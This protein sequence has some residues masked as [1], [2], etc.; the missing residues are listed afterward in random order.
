M[1]P[2]HDRLTLPL[3]ARRIF[4]SA[5][6]REFGT[7]RDAL[8]NALRSRGV[9]VEVQSAFRQGEGTTLSK[10]HDYIRGCERVLALVGD[11]SGA[12][13]PPDAVTPDL[14]AML[15]AGWD[16]ASYTQW[17]VIIARHY[18]VATFFFESAGFR[19]EQPPNS[20]DQPEAQARWRNFLFDGGWGM[21]RRQFHSADRIEADVMSLD[22]PRSGKPCNLPGS[23]GH[24]FKG[25]DAFLEDLARS[26]R[27][28]T[29][30]AI[31]GTA[32]HGL[33]GVG[34]T[35]AAI[36]YGYAR[37]DDYSALFFLVG[38]SPNDLTDGLAELCGV[39]ELEQKDAPDLNIRVAAVVRWMKANPGWLLVIDNVDDEAAAGAVQQFLREVASGKGHVLITS[40]LDDWGFGVESLALDLLSREAAMELLTEATP[41]RTRVADEEAALARLAEDQLGCLSLALVQAA[42]YIEARRISFAR[43]SEEFDKQA[44]GLLAKFG[45]SDARKLGYPMAVAQTWLTSFEQLGPEGRLLLDMLAWLSIEPLPRSL[46]EVWP[47]ADEID[48]EEGL[49]DLARYSFVRWE[50]GN[51]A[52]TVHRLVQEVARDLQTRDEARRDVALEAVFGWL[53]AA[54]PTMN[55]ND[56]RCWPVLLPLLPHV[57]RLFAWTR[58]LGPY[59]AQTRLYDENATLLQALARYA[60]AEPMFRRA[61]T[62][63]EA[64]NGPHHPTVANR[65]NNLA[66]LLRDT[67]RL[68]EAEPLYRCALTIDEAS[69]GPDHP[70]VAVRLNNLAGL[71]RATNR[72]S[73]AEPLYRRTLAI[74]E[75]SFGPDHPRVATCLNNIAELLRDTN[76]LSEAEPLYR[77]A[78]EIDE[79]SY[80]PDHPEVATGL[81]NLAGLLQATNRLV[82]AE[83]LFRRALAI[84]EASYGPDHPEVATDLNNL[85][86]LL[87]AT[88]R[89][90]EAEPLYRRVGAILLRASKACG[91]LLPHLRPGIINYVYCLN[92]LGHPPE[93]ISQTIAD[94]MTECGFDPT[95]LWPHIFG[96]GPSQ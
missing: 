28:S 43:Y 14:R 61:L 23:I 50:E 11:Y 29:A 35:R 59:G 77:R 5:A 26:F 7:V 40:R 86:G 78:L 52:I 12:Y 15:P 18:R 38:K 16:N 75:A 80:G 3:M 82:E 8:A 49:T 95:Q 96:D 22:W 9:T 19:A 48:L 57:L 89:R 93:Q 24:L 66:E 58:E 6:S 62:I 44:A 68:S 64:S 85:A 20:Q 51:A 30:A 87:E 81:I 79:A 4:I 53:Y 88:N 42:A 25:R 63:D 60:E 41:N 83:P 92:A 17:E 73:E 21:D 36:E 71:L 34:K 74:D 39:L 76:R 65:L 10:L 56:V 55:A 2:A 1:T 70:N 47:Q 84:D 32:M 67:N 91:H 54:N 31:V 72:F 90:V 13:P 69:F 45:K 46:W 37:Q 27:K 94:L 33:G